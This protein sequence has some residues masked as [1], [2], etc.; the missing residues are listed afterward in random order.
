M[1]VYN[2]HKTAIQNQMYQVSNLCRHRLS[3]LI[4]ERLSNAWACF[5]ARQLVQ[6]AISCRCRTLATHGPVSGVGRTQTKYKMQKLR[7]LLPFFSAHVQKQPSSTFDGENLTN[8]LHSQPV[9]NTFHSG[10]T[11]TAVCEVNLQLKNLTS[12]LSSSCLMSLRT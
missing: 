3:T 12:N 7:H 9:L 11:E 6:T 10:C 8:E 5:K 2:F 1:T 4:R